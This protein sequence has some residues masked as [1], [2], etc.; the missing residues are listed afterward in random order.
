MLG[1]ALGVVSFANGIPEAGRHMDSAE[2]AVSIIN[3]R[4]MG[5]SSLGQLRDLTKGK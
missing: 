2:I 4:F 3:G 5:L 1:V